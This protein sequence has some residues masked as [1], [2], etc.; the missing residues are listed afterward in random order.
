MELSKTRLARMAC[1]FWS[2]D[3]DSVRYIVVV[4]RDFANGMGAGGDPI[5]E[6]ATER[7]LKYLIVTWGD[8][9]AGMVARDG[10]G[11]TIP[12]QTARA[13]AWQFGPRQLKQSFR[14]A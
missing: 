3:I 8:T 2:L 6:G 4:A 12:L 11:A 10:K 7:R 14:I 9:T 13:S 1:M 5:T